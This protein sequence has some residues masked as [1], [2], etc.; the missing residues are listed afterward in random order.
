MDSMKQDNVIEKLK[1]SEDI[2]DRGGLRAAYLAYQSWR[3]DHESE[4]SLPGLNYTQN[5]LFF[6]SAANA[7][8][9]MLS[10]DDMKIRI[11]PKFRVTEPM[12]DMPEFSEAFNCARNSRM[13]RGFNCKVW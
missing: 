7:Y 10:P 6:I 4:L 12:S 5:Q 13:N 2:A 11:P 3:K 9:A 1:L 8:C